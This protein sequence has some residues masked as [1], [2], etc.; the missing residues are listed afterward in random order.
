MFDG[1]GRRR[2]P[3]EDGRRD[4]KVH[5]L[6]VLSFFGVGLARRT[7]SGFLGRPH[8][9]LSLFISFFSFFSFIQYFS[10][11]LFSNPITNILFFFSPPS[12][13]HTNTNSTLP[14]RLSTR[15][16]TRFRLSLT[17]VLLSARLSALLFAARVLECQRKRKRKEIWIMCRRRRKRNIEKRSK[18]KAQRAQRARAQ[19][20]TRR[21]SVYHFI[22]DAFNFPVLSGQTTGTRIWVHPLTRLALG[23]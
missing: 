17:R 8:P 18:H 12:N 14:P 10:S 6:S 23:R 7:D 15:G 4:G 1:C 11:I 13:K 3:V 2:R 16:L 22:D 9:H 5:F 21:Q 19:S 20:S